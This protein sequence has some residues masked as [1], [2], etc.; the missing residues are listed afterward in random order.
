MALA[1]GELCTLARKG[2]KLMNAMHGSF[3]QVRAMASPSLRPVCDFLREL[4]TL[5]DGAHVEIV[6]R[7]HQI[8]SYGVGPKKMT[9]HYAY[10]GVQKSHVN[11]GFYHGASLNDPG[12][13]LEGTGKK[14]RH[15]KVR[16][17]TEAENPALKGLVV[18]AIAERRRCNDKVQQRGST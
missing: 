4:I 15:V 7:R 18:E 6:W 5:L 11:L 1:A 2:I 17:V 10:I 8:S 14:L 9:E 13:L 16:N 3:S 12:G